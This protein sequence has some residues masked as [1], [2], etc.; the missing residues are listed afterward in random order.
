MTDLYARLAERGYAYG[1]AFAGIRALWRDG[2]DMYGE[3]AL[4]STVSA[5]AGRFGLHP[6]QRG[7]RPAGA[8]RRTDRQ[9]E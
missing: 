8:G 6:A 7:R 9:R 5:E 4:P 2:E 1:P 3:V